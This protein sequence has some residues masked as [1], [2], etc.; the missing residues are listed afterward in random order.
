MARPLRIELAGGLHH[1]TSRGNARQNI[2]IDDDDRLSWL[3][4]FAQVC[5][6]F[7]WVCHDYCLM[8]NDCH[9]DE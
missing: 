5:E 1:V 6:R 3:N 7:N 8:S 9:I 4:I 2:F